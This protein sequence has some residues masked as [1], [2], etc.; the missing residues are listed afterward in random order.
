[1]GAATHHRTR[2][3]ALVAIALS[4]CTG[5]ALE[6]PGSAGPTT[7]ATSPNTG[8]TSPST[9]AGSTH[10]STAVTSTTLP[11]LDPP[12]FESLGGINTVRNF[13]RSYRSRGIARWERSVPG[14]EDIRIAS[15]VDGAEQPALWVAPRRDRDRP[16]LV[17]LHSWSSP[18]DQHAGIPFAMWA[19]ENGWAVIAPQFRGVNDHAEAMGSELAVQD[20]VDA[21]DYATS[22]DG[23]DADRVYAVG[24]SGGGMMAL[25]LAG[26]HPDRVTA[27]AAW[28][29]VYD[30]VAFYQQ[31][32]AAG[33]HYAGEIRRVCGGDPSSSGPAQ[34]ECLRRSPITYLD[35][36]RE[37]GVPVFIG[38]GIADTLQRPSNAANAFN[39]LADPEDRLSEEEVEA[40]GRRRLPDHLSGSIATDT[41]FGEGDPAPVFARQSGAV[42]FVLFQASHEM[43]YAPALRWFATDPR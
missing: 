32:R 12:T 2:A 1:M 10:T 5:S 15:T 37:Q 20:V 3:L 13:T 28:G 11:P 40:I 6:P 34:E 35:T 33:R 31:S 19:Q 41:Y 14:V 29:P 22:Q 25:L 39:Q 26:R 7:S 21:I 27:V 38:Q 18:Y 16:L 23:V 24:L 30:L 8:A 43:V 9:T 36:A 42:W 17:V 4:A